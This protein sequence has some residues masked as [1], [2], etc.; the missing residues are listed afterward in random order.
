MNSLRRYLDL[1]LLA[2]I[3][4]A[5]TLLLL[6]VIIPRGQRLSALWPNCGS[7]YLSVLLGVVGSLGV[8]PIVKVGGFRF[9]HLYPRLLIIRYPPFWVSVIVALIAY[10]YLRMFL[11]SK[12]TFLPQADVYLWAWIGGVSAGAVSFGRLLEWMAVGPAAK[13]RVGLA[14]IRLRRPESEL[15]NKT[16]GEVLDRLAGD[17]QEINGWL[18]FEE[19]IG[20]PAHDWFGVDHQARELAELMLKNPGST[21]GIIG[22][23]GAGK[24]SL[25]K[26]SHHYVKDRGFRKQFRAD[27][28]TTAPWLITVDV[29]SWGFEGSNAAEHALRCG[30]RAL[31]E[32]VDCL[33]LAG[34]PSSYRAAIEKA[35]PPWWL[36]W[37]LFADSCED[38][39][40]ALGRLDRVVSAIGAHLVFCIEDADRNSNESEA[41]SRFVQLQ[42]MLDRLRDHEH[43]SFVLSASSSEFD[44]SF[45]FSR[46]CEHRFMVR[47]LNPKWA[48]A[49]VQAARYHAIRIYVDSGDDIDP[50]RTPADI[51]GLSK[52]L[53][54]VEFQLF[55]KDDHPPDI[56]LP[57]EDI[58]QL[59]SRPRRLKET[60]RRTKEIWDSSLH[61]EVDLDDLLVCQV[62]RATSDRAFDF[63]Q[64]WAALE[65]SHRTVGKKDID[66]NMMVQN[67]WERIVDDVTAGERDALL[68]LVTWVKG[69]PV[70]DTHPLSR[71]LG[72]GPPQCIAED[73]EYWRRI[74]EERVSTHDRPP[75]QSVLKAILEWKQGHHGDL[76]HGMD[77]T[78][79]YAGV[80]EQLQSWPRRIRHE[81]R[82]NANDLMQLAGELIDSLLREDGADAQLS[83]GC[84][85]CWRL[86]TKRTV[87]KDAYGRWVEAQITKAFKV[88][89]R[90]AMDLEQ[91]YAG[92]RSPFSDEAHQSLLRAV[93]NRAQVEWEADPIA[94]TKCLSPNSNQHLYTLNHLVVHNYGRSPLKLDVWR[95]L[96]PVLQSEMRARPAEIVPHVMALIVKQSRRAR[97]DPE[98]GGPLEHH[99]V[100]SVARTHVCE[101]IPEE[102]KRR[103]FVEGLIEA[104]DMASRDAWNDETIAFVQEMRSSC[105]EWLEDG[106]VCGSEDAAG[107]GEDGAGDAPGGVRG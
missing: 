37:F 48:G 35:P 15:V 47:D 67:L 12:L 84:L 24:T 56:S 42:A 54:S 86:F 46:L 82:L 81:L 61:G 62:I 3:S 31:S 38:P 36:S 10:H 29:D 65:V 95:W 7:T 94:L 33:G 71:R 66:T 98:F 74:W 4:L 69:K 88:S 75:D 2:A 76:V 80:F 90:L 72:E 44:F 57:W 27:H 70:V 23:F 40:D 5:S 92:E 16:A 83:S 8:W 18:K 6:P 13:P 101:L 9:R 25:L 102:D 68:R 96:V 73:G 97:E 17:P 50:T 104:S 51:N 28:G 30:I 93:L 58:L 55:V 52:K 41:H 60:L 79:G 63:L 19:P 103:E 78:N 14:S 45:D 64:E 22:G 34:I 49:V 100:M 87:D 32:Y 77:H 85:A 53:P 89:L 107:G 26:L 21:F 59:L 91:Y 11:P 43:I 99:S 106:V 20:T 39:V 1:V 105:N